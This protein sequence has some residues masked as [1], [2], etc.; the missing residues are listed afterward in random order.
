[1]KYYTFDEFKESIISGFLKGV[2]D[3][4]N[5]SIEAV[6]YCLVIFEADLNYGLTEKI[7][8]VLQI[9]KL[10][11]ENSNRIFI[12]QYKLFENTAKEALLKQNEF[13]L[14]IEERK[15]VLSWAKEILE[16]LPSMEIVNDPRAK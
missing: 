13:D 7:V 8:C 2:C 12:G 5:S 11:I 15:E 4:E 16:K 6:S 14:S 3:K 10:M 1:M 9:G